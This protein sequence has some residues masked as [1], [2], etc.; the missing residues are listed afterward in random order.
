M[1]REPVDLSAMF[2]ELSQ[3]LQEQSPDR[4]AHFKVQPRLRDEADPVLLKTVLGNLLDN[5]W[6]YSKE[7]AVTHIEFGMRVVNDQPFYFVKDNGV[8][9]DASGADRLF[10]PFQRLHLKSD[11]PGTGIGLASVQRII[12]RHGGSVWADS[13]PG[14]GATF[15]FSLD[16]ARSDLSAS[17]GVIQA[18]NETL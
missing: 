10:K 18:K 12:N 3:D 2:Q 6:K 9:F 1:K 15:Y 17:S 16:E 7:E 13:V 8:G 11:F 14:E 5:A 4:Q